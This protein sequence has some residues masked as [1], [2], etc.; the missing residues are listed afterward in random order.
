MMKPLPVLLAL[1]AAVQ[2]EVHNV[3]AEFATVQL[4]INAAVAGD[5]VLI[6]EGAPTTEEVETFASGTSGARITIDGQNVATIKRLQL[7][8]AY[9]TI[10]DLTITGYTG[11]FGA[12]V[13][14]NRN[15]HFIRM[16]G[17]TVDNNH[18][19]NV[20]HVTWQ[21]PSDYPFGT[22]AASD[23]LITNCIFRENQNYVMFSI[24]GARNIVE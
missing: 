19:L 14:F 16:G 7:D 22:D 9:I 5:T 17:V 24:S 1:A 11:T 10:K 18:A 12:S 4:A 2:A 6:S 21:S 8:H 3:P 13:A 20:Y 23:C 15:A